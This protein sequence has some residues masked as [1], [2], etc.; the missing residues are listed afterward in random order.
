M[1]KMEAEVMGKVERLDNVVSVANTA[2][3]YGPFVILTKR[4]FYRV[5]RTIK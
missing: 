5:G 4:N 2:Y 3:S 1:K